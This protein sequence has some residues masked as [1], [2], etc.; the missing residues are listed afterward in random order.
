MAEF[1]AYVF[2]FAW[3]LLFLFVYIKLRKVERDTMDAYGT[4]GQKIRR[5]PPRSMYF[6]W[7]VFQGFMEYSKEVSIVAEKRRKDFYEQ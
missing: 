3:N 2:I 5:K 1:I 6:S 7:K 4:L